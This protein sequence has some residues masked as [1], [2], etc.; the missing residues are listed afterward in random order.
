M[1]EAVFRFLFKYPLVAYRRGR[2]AFALGISP[3]LLLLA[4]IAVTAIVGLAA[5]FAFASCQCEPTVAK[6]A[7]KARAASKPA[8]FLPPTVRA[9]SLL[10]LIPLQSSMTVGGTGLDPCPH[11]LDVLPVTPKRS[12]RVFR[13]IRPRP[14]SRFRTR[15]DLRANSSIPHPQPLSHAWAR[16]AAWV[17]ARCVLW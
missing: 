6:T 15:P 11:S 13:D 4:A 2:L 5:M 7:M 16:G 12:G 14:V 3:W 9:I 17:V 1:G 10:K 8:S